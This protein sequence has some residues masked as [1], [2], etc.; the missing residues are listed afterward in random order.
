MANNESKQPK[1]QDLQT[2]EQETVQQFDKNIKTL[3]I[4][5]TLFCIFALLLIAVSSVI[6]GRINSQAE[7]YQEQFENAKTSGQSTIKNIQDENAALKRDIEVY[8]AE[9]VKVTAE[10]DSDKQ[11]LHDAESMLENAELLMKAQKEAYTGSYAKA[12]QLVLA[13]DKNCLQGDMLTIYNSLR[14]RLGI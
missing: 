4:Y 9:N 12:R 2:G 5:T 14:T 7:Y 3:W 1:T 8:K 6:Q 10:L 13:V 11:L